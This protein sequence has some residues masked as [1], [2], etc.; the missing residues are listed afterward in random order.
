MRCMRSQKFY[1]RKMKLS[2]VFPCTTISKEARDDIQP[3]SLLL[4]IRYVHTSR[5]RGGSAPFTSM[6]EQFGA[7]NRAILVGSHGYPL[8]SSFQASYTMGTVRASIETT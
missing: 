6:A 8:Y 1:V 4:G 5:C 7:G 3:G 2:P